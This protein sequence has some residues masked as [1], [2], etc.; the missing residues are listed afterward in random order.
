MKANYHT[1][2]YRC[3]HAQ[4]DDREY[5]ELAILSGMNVLGFA[6]HCPW[7]FENDYVSQIRMKPSEVDEYFSSL[8]ALKDEY[9]KDITI[10]IGFES[11]YIPELM[12]KQDKL[13]SGYPLDYMI[14]GQHFNEPE[15][16]S[17][18]NGRGTNDLDQFT[19]YI[20][21]IIE[22][23]ESGRYKYVAHPDLLYYAGEEATRIEQYTRLCRYFKEHDLPIEINLL[24]LKNGAHYPSDRL[25][26]I[27]HEVGN[28]AIIGIDAHTPE[29]LNDASSIELCET[30]V[31]NYDI[32]LIDY[33][34][35]L[36]PNIS[37]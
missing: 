33:L 36:G 18:Y 19:R 34:P 10:Y 1:H 29:L 22:G 31:L 7:I 37:E 11:E 35:G 21:L 23:L 26:R 30:V 5:I 25:L 9:A 2:T 27:A 8:L 12:E 15:Y 16:R 3:R 28:T 13:L 24:G 32:P 17:H 14:I 4:G 20:D 6:D